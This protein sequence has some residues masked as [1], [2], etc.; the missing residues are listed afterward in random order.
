MKNTTTK[1]KDH[2]LS[3]ILKVLRTNG[4]SSIDELADALAVSHM[5][6]RRDVA[7]LESDERIVRYHGGVRLSDH[8]EKAGYDLRSAERQNRWAKELIAREAASLINRGETVF[9]DAG[10]TMEMIARFLPPHNNLTVVTTALNIIN[11]ATDT[12][13]TT[14][15]A[16]G[17][18]YHDSSGVFEGPEAI[19]LLS[20]VRI[21]KAF[22]SANAVQFEL[23]VTCSNQFEVA[24]KQAVM[25]SSLEKIL[26]VDSSKLGRVVSAHFAEISDFDCVV[27]NRPDDATVEK[28]QSS[29]VNFRFVTAA[30]EAAR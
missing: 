30:E 29:G 12:P 9:I 27:V 21:T 28:C 2:R 20:R 10:T 18:I 24:G 3:M 1:N 25:K 19:A 17:G 5:T 26:V 14:V 16:S 22:L 13:G 6:V 11:I 23:G 4:P 7:V 15:I 8:E